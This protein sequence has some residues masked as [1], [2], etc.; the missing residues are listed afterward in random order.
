MAGFDGS[1]MGDGHRRERL[2]GGEGGVVVYDLLRGRAAPPF[3]AVLACELDPRGSVG[4]HVQQAHPEVVIGLEGDG[5][6]SVDGAPHSLGPGDVVHLP[7]GATLGLVNR[8]DAPLR[9]LIVK[10]AAAAASDP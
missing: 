5:E 6:A 1:G 7:L 4:P 3:T 2:F 10:A 9:Y 8:G